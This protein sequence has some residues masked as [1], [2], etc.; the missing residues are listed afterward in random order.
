VLKNGLFCGPNFYPIF[1]MCY[2]PIKY[3]PKRE[4]L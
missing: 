1:T 2:W 4:L 3:G